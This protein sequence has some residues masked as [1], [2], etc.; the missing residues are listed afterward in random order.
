MKVTISPSQLR[1]RITAPASKSAAQR[2][3]AAALLHVGE[4]RITGIGESEDVLAA[5]G[6]IQQLGAKVTK[7]E[8]V[9]IVKSRGIHS[10][11][12]KMHC[13][14]S[15]LG[16][17]MFTPVAALSPAELTIT[18]EGTLENR[19]MDVFDKIMPGLG[20]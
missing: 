14:E 16:L 17:R 2:A 4:S 15:G 1:G 12:K 8:D 5:L 6:V 19:P 9:I 7:E 11:G 18:G 20:V 10:A 13:G 3:L